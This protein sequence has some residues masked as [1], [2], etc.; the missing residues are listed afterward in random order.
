M[1]SGSI[2]ALVTPFRDGALDMQAFARLVDWQIKEGT[3]A[4]VPCGTTGESPTLSFDEHYRIIDACIEAA[5]GRVP[6]IAGCGSNDTATAIRHMRHAQAAGASAA[7]IVA[8][9]YNRPTQEGMLAHFRALADASDLPIVVYNVP[10]R[11]VA[12]I[13]AETM[14]KL[15]EIP[16]VV[17]TKDASG[18]LAR[19]TMHRAGAGADFCQLSGND[20]LWLPHAV[21]GG[22]GCI[23]VTANVAPRLCADFAAACA[24]GDWARAL[25]LHDRLFPLHKAMFTDA[26]PA[27]VKYALSRVHDWFSPDVRL[28]IIPASAASRAAVDAALVS[29]GVL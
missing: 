7:L 4:L 26:S 9:Y 19:V 8:P 29:A 13:S 25:V 12:D 21:L 10:G 15:A 11:T 3:S 16:T 6:V 5:A 24:A 1:F 2:P 17:A 20:D 22:A 18:D 28:P 14:C 27:P 23:S